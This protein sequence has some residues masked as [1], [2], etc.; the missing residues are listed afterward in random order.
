MMRPFFEKMYPLGNALGEKDLSAAMGNISKL[1]EEER[2]VC[3][4]TTPTS[5][6]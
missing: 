5:S 3:Q 1:E 2:L 4:C 6:G